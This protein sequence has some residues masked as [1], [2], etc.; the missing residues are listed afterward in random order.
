MR[1]NYRINLD[2]NLRKLKDYNSA[3]HIEFMTLLSI[4]HIFSFIV[5]QDELELYYLIMKS[6]SAFRDCFLVISCL[7]LNYDTTA[8]AFK[9]FILTTFPVVFSYLHVFRLP[10]ID[11]ET[12]KVVFVNLNY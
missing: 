10:L 8:V 3:N 1:L 4:F 2:E 5:S 9:A 7:W 11:N 12:Q 6:F